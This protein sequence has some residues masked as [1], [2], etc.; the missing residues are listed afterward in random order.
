MAQPEL[1][2]GE[3]EHGEEV[4]GVFFVSGGEA[5]EV[6]DAIEEAL[7]AIARPIEYRAEARFPAT[8][9]HRRDVWSRAGGLDLA[10]QPVGIVGLVGQH[11]GALVQVPEQLL[12]DRAIAR[13]ARRQDQ[14]E[15][16]TIGVDER[17]DLRGESTSRTTQSVSFDPPFP[18]DA[19]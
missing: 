15:R 4:G 5:S 12:G 1:G 18:P 6:F 19:S 13:L 3:F 16:Q 14:F 10:A 7:D 17:V 8:M 2:G 11:D 9:D